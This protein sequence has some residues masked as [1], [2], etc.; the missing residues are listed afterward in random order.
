MKLIE[1]LR[2][3]WNAGKYERDRQIDTVLSLI[4]DGIFGIGAFIIIVLV[5]MLV[6][7]FILPIMFWVIKLAGPWY[8]TLFPH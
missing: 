8:C 1:I 4:L 5:V 6:V 7:A 2:N 3:K